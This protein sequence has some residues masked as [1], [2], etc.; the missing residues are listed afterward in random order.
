MIRRIDKKGMLERDK[1]IALT[2][3]ILAVGLVVYGLYKADINKTLRL[4]LPGYSFG[5]DDTERDIAGHE[6][7]DIIVDYE[8]G[9]CTLNK[10]TC[11]VEIGPCYCASENQYNDLVS[12]GEKKV[13][14]LDESLLGQITCEKGQVCNERGGFGCVKNIVDPHLQTWVK[15]C[16]E[17]NDDFEQPALCDFDSNG[18]YLKVGSLCSCP[19][20]QELDS[21]GVLTTNL[22]QAYEQV[23]EK[24]KGDDFFVLTLCPKD[25]YCGFGDSGKSCITE[26]EL[27]QNN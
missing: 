20:R 22:Q 26:G 19:S 7:L 12:S 3:V 10:N 8:S 14:D 15:S 17:T 5:Q 13:A 9:K 18:A 21:N 27:P 1:I 4:I 23:G 2:L 25:N 24:I 6:K 16:K 11:Q